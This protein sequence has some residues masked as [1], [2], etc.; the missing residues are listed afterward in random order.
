MK[1]GVETGAGFDQI[2]TLQNIAKTMGLQIDPDKLSDRQ[3]MKQ[4]IESAF[5]DYQRGTR[6]PGIGSQSDV[7]F[8]AL[9]KQFVTSDMTPKTLLNVMNAFQRNIMVKQ[10]Y[11]D[12]K[13]NWMSKFGG[14]FEKDTNGHTF[15]QVWRNYEKKLWSDLKSGKG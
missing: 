2:T 5:S 10:A 14:P 11:V 15:T 3:F 4:Q 8:E 1:T 9:R 6:I 13:D 7:E 12:Q